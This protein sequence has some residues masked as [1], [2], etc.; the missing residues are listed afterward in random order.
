MKRIVILSG[1]GISAESGLLTFRGGGGLWEDMDTAEVATHEAWEKDYRKVLEF[2]NRRRAALK[3]VVPNAAHRLVAEMERWYDVTVVTQNIDDLHE[4]AG[5]SRVVHLHGELT[6][7]RPEDTYNWD[8]GFSEADVEWVGYEPIRPGD[9]GGESRSQLRPHVVLFGE[10]TPLVG[11]AALAVRETDVLVVV[12]TS[13]LVEPAA[14]LLD[15]AR[16]DCLVY[17]I[18]PAPVP[19]EDD[20]GVYRICEKATVGMHLLLRM[21]G[22]DLTTL[23]VM[24]RWCFSDGGGMTCRSFFVLDERG[25]LLSEVRDDERI[26]YEYDSRGRVIQELRHTSRGTKE[27]T[28]EYDLEDRCLMEHIREGRWDSDIPHVWRRGGRM[29]ESRWGDRVRIYYRPDGLRK[30]RIIGWY[31]PTA[32][33]EFYKWYRDGHLKSLLRR[34]GSYNENWNPASGKWSIRLGYNPA[35]RVLK[36]THTAI[37]EDFDYLY[38]D[39]EKGNWIR[40]E[41]RSGEHGTLIIVE[42]SIW[43]GLS[44]FDRGIDLIRDT[45]GLSQLTK[46]D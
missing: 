6:K 8:D 23:D 7:A 12:G 2:Y 26:L 16:S 13:L 20:L 27:T 32:D 41:A 30:H 14:S 37:D 19:V 11:R 31:G 4:R 15:E 43:Y 24:Q 25:R 36:E 18:D 9:T 44:G 1:A 17:V 46:W 21:L 42:R 22:H 40:R 3:D 33:E 39:D 38:Q 29:E 28:F 10:P 35:G 34:S 45:Q 5:S